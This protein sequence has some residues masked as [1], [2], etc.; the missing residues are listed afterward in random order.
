MKIK[1]I[2][3]V[4]FMASGKTLIS[5]K[6][7]QLL[8][9]DVVSTD[10]LIEK[11]DG[12]PITEIFQGSGETHFR[13]LEKEAVREVSAKEG[14]I[15][16]CGG[17]VVLDPENISN[18][19]KTGI[20]IY[21]STSPE[22]IWERVKGKKHRPLLNVEDPKAKIRE[23]LEARRPYYEQADH[24]VDTNGKSV[25]QVCSEIMELMSE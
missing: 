11:K 4:G 14:L 7:A 22:V 17:G 3:L 15:L 1:N 2:V 6:L 21:L 8:Q 10:N 12:R 16:D 24:I 9:R 5:N 23:L 13:A 18:L 19:K 20:I 25:E